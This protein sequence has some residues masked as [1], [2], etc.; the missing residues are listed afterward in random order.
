M[1]KVFPLL[2]LTLY[3]SCCS[4]GWDS[5]ITVTFK[6][7]APESVV[8][9]TVDERF[10]EHSQIDFPKEIPPQSEINLFAKNT[11]TCY[12]SFTYKDKTYNGTS[13]YVDDY[14]KYTIQ[15]AEESDQIVCKLFTRTGEFE[16][17]LDIT[18]VE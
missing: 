18:G 5:Q 15:F 13:G 2:L 17:Y 9:E 12:F 11:G 16:R 10:K 4:F 6:N 8:L 3:V 1:Y 14:Y 7:S